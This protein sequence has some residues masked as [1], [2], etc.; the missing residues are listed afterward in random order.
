MDNSKQVLKNISKKF[1]GGAKSMLTRDQK[2]TL[3]KT[4]NAVKEK[5]SIIGGSF[6]EKKV[7]P[8][9]CIEEDQDEED[10]DD[11]Y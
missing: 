7:A 11:E 10:Q 9:K 3:K 6:F 1:I 5:F 8:C 4:Y 2:S